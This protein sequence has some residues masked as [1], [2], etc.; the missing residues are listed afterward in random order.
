MRL[1]PALLAAGLFVLSAF[2]PAFA[3]EMVVRTPTPQ[4]IRKVEQAAPAE[5]AAK[6]AQARKLLVWGRLGA[7][8]PNAI[9][10]E[11]M[12]I[13]GKKTGAFEAV[14]S[15]DPA[16]LLPDAL[17]PFDAILMNNVH[18]P[19]PFLPADLKTLPAEEQAKLVKQNEA[20]HK[21]I[22]EFVSGG[23]GIAGIHAA[24]AAFQKWPE[25]GEMMGGYYGGHMAGDVAIK[26]EDA[27][28]P[29]VAA[30]G[31][32]T[33]RITDE[34]YFAKE[35]YSRT[36]VRVLL[37]LDLKEMED[38]AKRPDK[39][40]AISWVRDYGKGR[41]FY[42]ALGHASSTYWNPAVLR[43]WLAGIQFVIGDLKAD[44]TPVAGAKATP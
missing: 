21:A 6:P 20:I 11:T 3:A 9:A 25:Y 1:L 26:P 35:P 23:K 15:E 36:K 10:A 29:L 24:T 41:V 39:D 37:G 13:L 32:K 42:C 22:L 18:Q 16:A 14:I 4:E 43:H 19:D 17:K 28:S 7:H 31:G 40:Y 2:T 12:K 33:F 8:D 30:F 5:P 34:I 27:A 44:T 38:P